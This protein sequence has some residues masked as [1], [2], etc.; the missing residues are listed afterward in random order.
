MVNL[1]GVMEEFS[2]T[3][4]IYADHYS[5]CLKYGSDEFNISKNIK[6]K[7]STLKSYYDDFVILLNQLLEKLN[8]K[9]KLL[10]SDTNGL[11]L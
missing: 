11:Y 5:I 7:D 10:I 9:D 6:Y 8:K 1:E 2:F 3:I 4:E